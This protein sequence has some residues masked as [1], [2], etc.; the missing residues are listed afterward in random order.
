MPYLTL[1]NVTARNINGE[2]LNH[3]PGTVLSD[4]ELSDFIRE[5][6]K[7]GSE[8]YR[9]RFEPLTE[10]EAHVHRVRATS[11]EGP[12]ILEGNIIQPPWDDYV[13]LH[14]T[15]IVDRMRDATVEKVQ[16]VRRYERG[17]MKRDMVV[18]YVHP[19]EHEPWLGYD[20]MDVRDVLEKFSLMGPDAID[21]A[22]VYEKAHKNRPAVVEYDAELEQVPEAAA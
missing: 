22:V 5:K 13:G 9:E 15:E 21:R 1:K 8:W 11:D 17:G 3:Q 10:N 20:N 18:N 4:W 2:S 19:A 6:V 12:H 14:P 7:E 16:H